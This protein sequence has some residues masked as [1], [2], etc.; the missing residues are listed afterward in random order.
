MGSVLGVRLVARALAVESGELLP[1]AFAA[2]V[3][4]KDALE[5]LPRCDFLP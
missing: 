1:Y 3:V 4:G 2:G 5:V